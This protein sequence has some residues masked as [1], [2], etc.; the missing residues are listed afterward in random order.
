MNDVCGGQ[1]KS[2]TNIYKHRHT[3]KAVR[4]PS[5]MKSRLK[6]GGFVSKYVMAYDGGMSNLEKLIHPLLRRIVKG[7][8]VATHRANESKAIIMND[9]HK[10]ME[11]INN[12]D[13]DVGQQSMMDQ[14]MLKNRWQSKNNIGGGRLY[15][16]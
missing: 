14:S 10:D 3:Y 12:E 1:T 5:H 2:Y 11:C 9:I 7:P 15:V 6:G 8:L 13:V 4:G 16:T